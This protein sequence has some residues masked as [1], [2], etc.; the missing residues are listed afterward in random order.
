MLNSSKTCNNDMLF[1]PWSFDPHSGPAPHD[2][3]SDDNQGLGDLFS[4]SGVPNLKSE[5]YPAFRNSI[6]TPDLYLS[7]IDFGLPGDLLA[8]RQVN[9][10]DGR[11]FPCEYDGFANMDPSN[12]AR[13]DHCMTNV[14]NNIDIYQQLLD[15]TFSMFDQS[16]PWDQ[17]GAWQPTSAASSCS[18]ASTLDASAGFHTPSS[19]PAGDHEESSDPQ[20]SQRK[21]SSSESSDGEPRNNNSCKKKRQRKRFTPELKKETH[22]TRITGACLPCWK[23]KKRCI[24]VSEACCKYCE[25][26]FSKIPNIPCFRAR[27]TES[28]LFR[29]GPT[30]EFLWTRRRWLKASPN[31][32]TVWASPA[33]EFTVTQG[34][35]LT[36]NLMAKQYKPLPDDRDN[37]TWI[38][39][40]GEV[41]ALA[42]PP[43]AISDIDRAQG[44]INRYVEDNIFRYIQEHVSSNVILWES[45]SMALRMSSAKGSSLLRNALKLWV[46]SR[47]IETPWSITGNETFGMTTNMEE[48]SPYYGKIPVTPIMDFQIDNITIHQLLIPLRKKLLQELQRKVLN[49]KP[50]DFLEIYL[51][52]FILLHNM[53]LTIAHDRW[54]AMRYSLQ[55]RFS[56]Y[57]LIDAVF[58]GANILLAHFHHVSKGY[59]PFSIDWESGETI[60]LAKSNEEEVRYM[61]D[62]IQATKRQ[63]SGLK[64]LREKE[65]YEDSMYWCSQLFFPGWKPVNAP[66]P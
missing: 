47:I 32:R 1:T 54:F 44:T 46:G 8:S 24:R 4:A 31:D 15:T 18:S 56:N 6:F 63:E 48:G 7:S 30:E 9:Y 25:S 5:Q 61:K 33:K 23:N 3:P 36:L 17:P 38:D 19:S 51:T 22:M 53:E 11:H 35:G 66:T 10:P 16:A 29:R 12:L 40:N 65:I 55:N 26:I 34:M 41:A 57:H 27:M 58:Q 43:Y 59:A 60:V 45:F 13:L 14:E 49:N 21:N 52:I 42:C 2:L 39:Q 50:E 37:Y 64:M 62:V 20:Q 28:E